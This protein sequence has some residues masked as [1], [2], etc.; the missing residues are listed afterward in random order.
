MRCL[1]PEKR[2]AIKTHVSE[3]CYTSYI[4]ISPECRANSKAFMSPS[5]H[6]WHFWKNWKLCP[7]PSES[8]SFY[9]L[10][11]STKL[12]F[13]LSHAE[14]LKKNL[15]L[16]RSICKNFWVSHRLTFK[17]RVWNIW[18]LWELVRW[19]RTLGVKFGECQN[20]SIIIFSMMVEVFLV[21]CWNC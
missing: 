10:S 17:R 19:F 15:V 5:D 21:G 9:S 2:R 13:L 1:L 18:R 12:F 14:V 20:F 7:F 6:N 11:C 3:K 4:C 8:D 16:T